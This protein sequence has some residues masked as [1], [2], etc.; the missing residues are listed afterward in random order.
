MK[1]FKFL[2]YFIFLAG[3][4][5]LAS[6]NDDTIIDGGGIEQNSILQTASATDN[7]S[8]FVDAINQTGLENI[9]SLSGPFTVLAPTNEAFQALIDSNPAWNSL[10][11]ID[12]S[13]LSNILLFH[14]LGVQL[15]STDFVDSFITTGATGPNNEQI[16]LQI[17]VSGG[18]RFNGS[19]TLVTTDIE[20]SNGIL[21]IIDEVML[22]P[23]LEDIL[24]NNAGFSLLVSAFTRDDLAMDFLSLLSSA[25]PFTVFAP[26]DAAFQELIDANLDWDSLADIPLDILEPALSYHI[27]EEENVQSDQLF[28]GQSIVTIGLDTFNIDLSYGP[29]INTT[30]GQNVDI[31][32][33]NI[34]GVNGVVHAI[35]AVLLPE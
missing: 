14:V 17:D 26:T 10:S 9:F 13:M 35:D 25:E 33:P 20:A 30:S 15:T 7:L 27:L 19:A 31:I 32:L 23:S 22:L 18:I 28:E 1:N 2:I 11:D 24:L 3:A 34:Q 29:V 4:L 12:N 8:L 6:C 5:F 16:S 21:H